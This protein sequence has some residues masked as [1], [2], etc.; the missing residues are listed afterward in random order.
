MTT[1]RNAL[2]GAAGAGLV[3]MAGRL[4]PAAAGDGSAPASPWS[5]GFGARMRLVR[6]APLGDKDAYGAGIEIALDPGF[7]TY[8]RMPGEAGVPPVFAW[9]S[10]RNLAAVVPDWPAP[11]RFDEAGLSVIGYAGGNVV[12]PLR[13]AAADAAAPVELALSL[14]YAAC[15]TICVP[16]KADAALLLRHDVAGGQYAA[17][18]EAAAR[19]VPR[20]VE[21]AALGLDRRGSARLSLAAGDRGLALLPVLGDRERILDLFVE[22]P[23]N[24]LFGAPAITGNGAPNAVVLPLIDHPK[25]VDRATDIPFTLT[26]LTDMRTLETTIATRP[27]S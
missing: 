14:A 6:G 10:S 26:L 5:V 20:R 18:I 2:L 1:R 27:V 8:W 9:S 19:E 21:A 22:G 17:L 3:A 13:I 11:R 16:E 24:W 25:W 23:E 12:L 7:K 15:K 4:R